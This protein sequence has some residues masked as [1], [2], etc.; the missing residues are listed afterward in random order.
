M[1][2]REARGLGAIRDCSGLAMSC[3][4]LIL[5]TR[6]VLVV[7]FFTEVEAQ[8]AGYHKAKNCP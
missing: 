8:Q 6:V 2:A 4:L 5:Q 1:T 7:P 3:G